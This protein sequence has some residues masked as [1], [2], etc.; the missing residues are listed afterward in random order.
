MDRLEL[1]RIQYLSDI[2]NATVSLRTREDHAAA[3]VERPD[4][5]RPVRHH[6]PFRFYRQNRYT[7][8]FSHRRA[9]PHAPICTPPSQA[10]DKAQTDHK[11]AEANGSTDPTFGVDFGRQLGDPFYIVGSS[12]VFRCA[13]ST[14]IR[15]K[16]CGPSSMSP[17]RSV[18]ATRPRRRF[19]AMSIPPT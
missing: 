7:R 2:Q 14:G 16:N 13:S 6:R 1:Q 8:K 19:S 3:D 12:R 10:V 5:G 15:A 11:L 9:R 18:C 4:A 17:G